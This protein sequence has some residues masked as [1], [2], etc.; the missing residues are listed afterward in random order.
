MSFLK[1][2]PDADGSCR[3]CGATE[4]LSFEHVPPRSAGNQGR[5]EMLGIEAWLRR[6]DERGTIVQKGSGAYTLC[7]DCNSLAGRL[8][9]PEFAKLWR[10]GNSMLA[11][12]K[13]TPFEV[14][15]GLDGGYVHVEMQGVRAGRIAKQIVTMLLAITPTS[16]P[17]IHAELTAYAREPERVGLPEKYQLYLVAYPGPDIARFNGGTGIWRNGDILFVVSLCYPPFSY[18]LSIDEKEPALEAG[19]ITEFAALGIDDVARV[20]LDL[21]LGFGHTP[22]P[23]DYRTKAALERDRVTNKAEAADT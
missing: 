15:R 19:N 14:D 6:G 1:P 10:T 17:P 16:F 2:K 4:N 9:V 22:L 18:V 7:R 23:L 13:P 21:K 12:L 3:V 5:A 20:D 8:Y 11:R